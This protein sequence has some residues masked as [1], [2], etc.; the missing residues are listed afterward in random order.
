MP[1]RTAYPDGA[2]CWIDRVT[3][4]LTAAQHWYAALFGWEY[5]E[6]GGNV[7]AQQGGEIVAGFGVAPV[8]VEAWTVYL[9]TKDLG[10]TI[11]GAV[12]MGGRVTMAPVAVGEFGRLAL[13]VDPAGAA[14]GLWEGHRPEGVVLADEAGSACRYELRVGDAG[15]AEAGH[16]YRTLFGR[17]ASDLVVADGSG[18]PTWVVY[19]GAADLA[20]TVLRALG[21]G[22]RITGQNADGSVVLRDSRG[23]VFGLTG[24]W[25]GRAAAGP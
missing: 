3:A 4:D 19:F 7:T 15:A 16:F 1:R 10:A 14:V 12:R 5:T 18:R 8:P 21:A 9:A 22:A 2:P 25:A 11:A 17:A 20:G 23:A 24:Q 6:E 13:A